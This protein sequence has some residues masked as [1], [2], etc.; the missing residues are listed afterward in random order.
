MA[1]S[2]RDR[3]MLDVER[4]WRFEAGS[5]A[6]RIRSGL[7]MSSTRYYRLL[8]ELIDR[9]DALDADP[10]LVRRLRR[11]RTARRRARFEGPRLRQ[12]SGK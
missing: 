5:K 11:E 7:G 10:L 4:T 8:G 3:H 12:G 9:P 2:E 6:A 1:L